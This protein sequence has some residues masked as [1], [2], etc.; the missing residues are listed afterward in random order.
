MC[1]LS[2]ST[3]NSASTKNPTTKPSTI[4]NSLT[5]SLRTPAWLLKNHSKPTI[6]KELRRKRNRPVSLACF[7]QPKSLIQM[8]I[9]PRPWDSS[10]ESLMFI[11]MSSESYK[12]KKENRLK[13]RYLKSLTTSKSKTL[14]VIWLQW[15]TNLVSPWSKTNWEEKTSE[16]KC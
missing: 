8:L 9:L 16:T 7:L 10:K 2:K 1:H 12:S 13:R 14:L 11:V 4:G 5:M 3:W 6:S 15:K